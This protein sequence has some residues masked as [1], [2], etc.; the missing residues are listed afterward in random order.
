MTDVAAWGRGS[1]W[2]LR[3]IL[4]VTRTATQQ[5]GG[6]YKN[7]TN[8]Q[9]SCANG[10]H[11]PVTQSSE[12]TVILDNWSVGERMHTTGEVWNSVRNSHL[13]EKR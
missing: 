4:G 13:K 7:G 3:A 10:L 8:T 5:G 2:G 11:G 1:G 9:E 12:W 6:M